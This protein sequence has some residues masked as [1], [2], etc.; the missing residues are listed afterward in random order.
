MSKAKIARGLVA[1]VKRRLGR[2][3]ALKKIGPKGGVRGKP[4]KTP[5]AKRPP[6]T[7]AAAARAHQQM[8]THGQRAAEAMSGPAAA[9]SSLG[10]KAFP[11]ATRTRTDLRIAQNASLRLG[12]TAKHN[13]WTG[14]GT[15]AQRVRQ[16]NAAAFGKPVSGSNPIGYMAPVK[17][18][19]LSEALKKYFGTRRRG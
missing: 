9:A 17:P 6:L 18:S 13:P 11:V 5:K 1:M 8:Y 7:P 4:G 12:N 19:K 3:A 16:G 14:Q 10:K 2:K 15:R